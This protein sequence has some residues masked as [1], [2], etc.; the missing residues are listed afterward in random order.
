MKY[1]TYNTSIV[2]NKKV[3]IEVLC[4]G[5]KMIFTPEQVLACFLRKAKTYFEK[6]G[7][8]GNE[9]VISVPT[10]ASNVERQAYLDA[11]EIA[12]IKCVRLINESTATALTYGFFR[13]ADLDAKKPRIVA[14][15]DFGHSK[16]TITYCSFVPGKT[17]VIMSHS[18]RNLGAR[19]IDFLLFDIF[20]T[21]FA[22]KY[23]CDPR[24]DK[25]CRL[26]MLDAI[27][28]M[29]KLLTANKEAEISCE[30]LMDDQD[31]RKM[32]KRTDLETLMDPFMRD[33]SMCLKE[34]LARSGLSSDHIQYVELVGEATRIPII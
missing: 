13:K 17:K 19:K 32:F 26:R 2:E 3:G 4:R 27:E 12:G 16:L 15:V 23:G 21:E 28:K 25:R 14:F 20:A 22:K 7:M 18:N 34:S 29:R 8:M 33:F 24:E 1:L 6:D 11:A 30:S 10:Y 9:M 31:F 5:E